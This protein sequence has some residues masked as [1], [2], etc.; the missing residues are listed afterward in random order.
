MFFG[1]SVMSDDMTQN[2]SLVTTQVN[3]VDSISSANSRKG[4]VSSAQFENS[5]QS[6][7][8][9]LS[10]NHIA[11]L[12]VR[13]WPLFLVIFALLAGSLTAVYQFKIPYVAKTSV[14]IN[15]SKNSSL[16]SFA[17]QFMGQESALKVNEAKKSNS[18]VLKDIEYLKTVEFYQK[19]LTELTTGDHSNK[20]N[21]GEKTG[22]EH[23]KTQVMNDKKINEMNND[24]QLSVIRSLD[25]LMKINLTSDYEIEVSTS[26]MDK[27]LAYFV[28]NRATPFIANELRV[29][30]E[31]DLAKIKTFL[32]ERKD[33]L[34]KNIR[35]INQKLSDFQGK[36]ENLISLSSKDKVGEYLSELMVRKN[37]IR[38]K[39]SEN[40]KIIQSLGGDSKRRDSALY[41]NSGKIH[42]L[43]IE[44]EMLQERLADLQKTVGSVTYQAKAIPT[45][46]IMYDELKRKS[47]IEFQNYKDTS[48]SL[49]KLEAY[50]LSLSNKYEVLESAQYD[51]VKP[52]V[53]FTTL[54]MLAFV[55]TQVLGSL[56]IYIKSIWNTSYVTAKSTRNIMVVDS[57]SLDPRVFIE[58]SKIKFR[59]KNGGFDSPSER[60]S[61]GIPK[62]NAV[63]QNEEGIV[64]NES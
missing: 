34:D 42:N 32:T 63:N 25:S 18:G 6:L 17:S 10:L 36:P 52:L 28:S 8:E 3:A 5:E 40:N 59:L 51:K 20:L 44:N 14:I 41:G 54:M 2:N 60:L 35:E 53:G 57:H 58:N 24:E 49:S 46:G 39:I 37:E 16:Q 4:R 9:E 19:L 56:I 11:Q 27:D 45:A 31:G 26:S 50:Q 15:D 30:Q 13:N 29:R 62:R 43:K 33:Q 64:D 61:F 38:M 1:G 23:F 22:F 21:L 47:D 12:L 7:D 48:E 55:L